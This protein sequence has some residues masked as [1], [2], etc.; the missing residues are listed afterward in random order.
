M[1]R[2]VKLAGREAKL[3]P[4]RSACPA[5]VDVPRYVRFIAEGKYDQ[6]LAVVR[7]KLPLP[8]VCSYICLRFC[9]ARCRRGE[10]SEPIAIMALKRFVS[11]NHSGLWKEGLKAPTPSGKKVAIAGSGA[12][13]L[14]AG[15]YLTRCGHEVTIF[16]ALSAPGGMLRDA[17]SKKRL[18]RE[19]LRRDIDDI[20]QMGVNLQLNS[21]QTSVDEL[22]ADG[23]DAVFLAG[24][25]IAIEPGT[26]ATSRKGVF[27][28]G[29]ASRSVIRAVAA[30]R[31]AASSID[32]YLGGSG[33][34][35]ERLVEPEEVNP[36]LGRDEGFADLG[37]LTEPYRP[38]PPQFAGLG[39]IVPPLDEKAAV[40][41]AKRCLRCNLRFEIS[42]VILPP[43]KWLAF[44]SENVSAVPEKEGVFQLRDERKMIIYIKGTANLRQ[45][46]EAELTSNEKAGYFDYEETFMYTGRESELLQKFLQE[47]GRLPE[48]NEELEELF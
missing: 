34:I 6:A 15:Y 32:R 5:G 45:E 46:L 29:D 8:S 28:S 41:E 7:E 24:G 21:G 1:D 35:D 40:K 20:L 16:E 27:A 12:A 23:F 42:P 4:C 2:G 38:P 30:G 43:E 44:N 9:E 26:L 47:H 13:G 17:I 39:K 22:F 36:W 37:C 31:Q 19:A 14:I 3:V 25:S 11:D 48:D 18:P 10:V 33:K